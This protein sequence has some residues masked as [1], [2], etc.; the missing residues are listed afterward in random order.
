MTESERIS[1]KEREGV[2]NVKQKER[3]KNK[4]R[5]KAQKTKT[6]ASETDED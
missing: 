5:K 4:K 1:Q 2:E 3:E 6:L